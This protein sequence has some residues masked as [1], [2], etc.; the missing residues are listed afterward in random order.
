MQ[1][2]EWL[3]TLAEQMKK[4]MASGAAASPERLTVREFVQQF[5][6]SR[7]GA[8]IVSQIRKGLRN[9]GLRTIPDFVGVWFDSTIS[10]QLISE[11]EDIQTPED[12]TV[13]IGTLEAAHTRPTYVKPDHALSV[14]TSEMLLNDYSQLPVMTDIRTVKG[15]VSWKS[16]G[17]RYALGQQP[18]FVRD[19]MDSAKE[20]GINTPLLTALEEISEHSYVLVRGGSEEQNA[21][22]GIV[23]ASDVAQQFKQ[24]TGPFLLIGEI[25]GNLRNLV[26]RKFT[27]DEMTQAAGGSGSDQSIDSA[28]DLTF[29][30]YCTLLG[31]KE[32]WDRLELS[33][34]RQVFIK[35][36]HSVREVRN[37][38]M[39]F[40]PDG[41]DTI[42]EK[43]LEDV[44]TFFRDLKDMKVM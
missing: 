40:N 23:T 26:F 20:V 29:G 8:Y 39:H 14:A 27:V 22:T 41:L 36:L 21:I 17:A 7:R 43:E 3:K 13:R 1:G 9:H 30:G 15:V 34:D 42:Q 4:D 19:C 5:G 31:K 6:Y 12:P 28:A 33:I 10:I 35:R 16:I 32:H 38:V 44:A 2:D 24:L 37:D 25:E 11:G 18:E